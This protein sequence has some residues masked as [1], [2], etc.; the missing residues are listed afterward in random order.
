MYRRRPDGRDNDVG[1][2]AVGATDVTFILPPVEYVCC[3]DVGPTAVKTTAAIQ[4]VG[5]QRINF[6]THQ[7]DNVVGPT[8]AR[9][10]LNNVGK[11]SVAHVHSL[12][13]KSPSV[14]QPSSLQRCAI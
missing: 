11:P 3:A 13:N 8:S 4:P 2:V 14:V 12:Y 6:N 10:R 9:Y 7:S 5:R 1:N